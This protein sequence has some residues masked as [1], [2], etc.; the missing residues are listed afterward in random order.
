M[1]VSVDTTVTP[2]VSR[3]HVAWA[4]RASAAG[5]ARIYVSS[6][7]DGLTWSAPAAADTLGISDDFG[8]TLT[9]GHQF[10]PQLTFS[11]GRLMLLYYDQRLDHTLGLAYPTVGFPDSNGKFYLFKRDPKGELLTNAGRGLHVHD[12]RHDPAALVAPAHDRP[13][14]REPEALGQPLHR[15]DGLAVQVRPPGR[16]QW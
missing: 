6:S 9:R 1:A 10:M 14:G 15:D 8:N 13:S 3:F 16:F 5:D 12:R 4:A 11:Q 7:S 2:A